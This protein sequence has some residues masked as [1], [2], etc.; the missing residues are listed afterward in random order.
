MP[1]IKQ[2]FKEFFNRKELLMSINSEEVYVN[3]T[4]N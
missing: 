2:I 1:K 3:D 4:E